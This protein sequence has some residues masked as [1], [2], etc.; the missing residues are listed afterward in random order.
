LAVGVSGRNAGSA[1]LAY[2]HLGHYA[3]GDSRMQQNQITK[4]LS[5]NSAFLPVFYSNS[6]SRLPTFHGESRQTGPQLFWKITLHFQNNFPILD[7]P[8]KRND[9]IVPTYTSLVD[10]LISK[11]ITELF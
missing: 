4:S 7:F 1:V 6:Y 3:P 10:I 8:V 2:F 5:L 11:I 9:Y